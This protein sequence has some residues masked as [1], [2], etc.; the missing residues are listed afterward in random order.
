V[1]LTH[2]DGDPDEENNQRR[3]HY[4]INREDKH[5]YVHLLLTAR[6]P[7]DSIAVRLA[8]FC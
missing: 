4:G 6:A 5:R 1:R 3:G 8:S 2:A 7:N